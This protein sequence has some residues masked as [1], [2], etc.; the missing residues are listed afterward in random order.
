MR[1]DTHYRPCIV[2]HNMTFGTYTYI[3]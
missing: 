2:K 3:D 1:Y